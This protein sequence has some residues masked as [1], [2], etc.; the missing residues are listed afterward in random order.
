MGRV[1]GE[2]GWRWGWWVVMGVEGWRW[3]WRDGDG[4]GGMEVWEEE[5]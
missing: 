1:M 4:G 2:V 3:G 5:W